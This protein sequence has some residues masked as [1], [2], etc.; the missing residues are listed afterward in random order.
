MKGVLRWALH[1]STRDFCP[2]LAALVGPVQNIF[3]LTVHNFSSFVPI[4]QQAGKAVV[5]GRLSLTQ[6]VSLFPLPPPPF[7]R[8]IRSSLLRLHALLHPIGS[9]N[10]SMHSFPSECMLCP[11]LPSARKAVYVLH[12]EK[13]DYSKREVR[14][15]DILYHWLR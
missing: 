12:R 15:G 6:C 5:Q 7:P 1:S 13:K 11:S 10:Q 3:F 4:A 14:K 2:A 9:Y 8:I